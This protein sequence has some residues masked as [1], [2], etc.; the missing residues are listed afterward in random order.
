MIVGCLSG[1]NRRTSQW[2]WHAGREMI[3]T[4]AP[5]TVYKGKN[6]IRAVGMEADPELGEIVFMKD[7]HM[8][9]Q[10]VPAPTKEPKP[11]QAPSQ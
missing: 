5:V 8:D 4:A 1:F 10:S 3:H 2:F 11:E 6:V 7:V 9:I